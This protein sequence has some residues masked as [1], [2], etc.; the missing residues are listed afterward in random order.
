M[1]ILSLQRRY[2][3]VL[4]AVGTAWGATL[5][6]QSVMHEKSFSL[7]FFFAAVT[8]SAGVGGLWPGVLAT[9]LSALLCDYFFLTPYHSLSVA[10]SDLPLLVLFLLVALLING[11]SARLR[12]ATQVADRRFHD[13]VQNLEAIVWEG[14]PRTLQF[15]FVSQRAEAL[16]GY[17]ARRWL[18]DSDF[19][20]RILH[21]DDQEEV[22]A[23]Y[24]KAVEETGEHDLEYRVLTAEGREVWLR[25]TIHVIRD[26]GGQPIRMTGLCMDVTERKSAAK[27]LSRQVV[28]VQEA[29]RRAIARELHDEVGQVLT[30]LKLSLETALRLPPNAT[31]KYLREAITLVNEL[32]AHVG[33]LSLDLRPAML[34]DFGLLPT[35]LWHFQRYT[36]LT[37]VQV[38]FGH[39]GLERRFPH[40]LETTAYRIV[41]E[42]L[43]NVARHAQ[44]QEVAVRLWAT[45]GILGIQV[46]DRGGGFDPAH[47][48]SG[49]GTGGLAGMRE[50]ATLVDGRLTVETSPGNGVCLTAEFPWSD[51][52][53]E[54]PR[55]LQ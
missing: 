17:P 40:E 25:E 20:Q 46:L 53:A 31:E 3:F 14:N 9:L 7:V 24:R 5:L 37:G 29:E 28:R 23:R 34:D 44:V 32:V 2:G 19:R 33:D 12:A 38:Q 4:L 13:L 1:Q 36:T 43:T 48:Q 26:D 30:G 6:L 15:T 39:T 41:Q 35:L 49:F 45:H 11:L 50:R 55:R 22:L 47:L 16:L 54:I 42:A 18:A 21:P 10:R 52:E 8:L 27:E 51:P